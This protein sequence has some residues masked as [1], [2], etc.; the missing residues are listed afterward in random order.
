MSD[1]LFIHLTA[2]IV[3]AHVSNN[4]VASGDLAGLIARV[5][6]ALSTVAQPPAP[7]PVKQEPAVSIRASVKPDYIVCLE[8]GAKL[9]TLKRHLQTHHSMTP[10]EYRAKWRLLSDYPMVASSYAEKRSALAKGFGFGRKKAVTISPAPAAVKPAGKRGAGKAKQAAAVPAAA[11][12]PA[13]KP[14]RKPRAK[15]VAAP[16]T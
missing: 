9:K 14:A 8:D 16:A 11:P 3:A 1:D 15:K 13:A 6:T 4:A 12:A 7:E 5:F 10:S 2:D